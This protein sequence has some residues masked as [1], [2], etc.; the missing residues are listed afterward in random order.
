MYQS[1]RAAADA[2][3]CAQYVSDS[4]MASHDDDTGSGTD[5]DCKPALRRNQ[6]GS[7]NEGSANNISITTTSATNINNGSVVANLTNHEVPSI[8][9]HRN[10]DEFHHYQLQ[11]HLRY[12]QHY[13][14]GNNQ[15]P[16][17]THIKQNSPALLSI[18][19]ASHQAYSGRSPT[20]LPYQRSHFPTPTAPH[21]PQKKKLT[22]RM[23]SLSLDSPESAETLKDK[24]PT[25]F[26][27]GSSSTSHT[28]PYEPTEMTNYKYKGGSIVSFR[29]WVLLNSRSSI[30]ELACRSAKLARQGV[31][32][33][34]I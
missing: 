6:T 19:Q 11:P 33:S 8:S 3:R 24:R 26:Y 2:R 32:C 25:G 31:C 5:L 34:Q 28:P 18:A 7:S 22:L 29:V 10:S 14:T 21:S 4:Y 23:K 15:E 12:N 27:P 1:L 16:L 30:I 13:G 9:T 17:R 20:H